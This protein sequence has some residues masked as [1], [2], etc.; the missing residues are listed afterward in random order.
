MNAPE[1]HTKFVVPE[2]LRKVSY[3]R[4]TKVSNAGT[5]VVQREDH[6]LGNTLRMQL[7]R[8]PSV[9]FAGYQ[10]PHPLEHCLKVK[11]QTTD[12]STPG[13]AVDEALSD[14]QQEFVTLKRALQDEL[15]QHQQF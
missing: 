3:E 13:K 7:H 5:F 8:D 9:T 2:G 6:T 10:I 11:V 14:L 1:R 4:D 15:A 12:E